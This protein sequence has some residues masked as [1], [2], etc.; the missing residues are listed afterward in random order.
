REESSYGIISFNG[1]QTLGGNAD[2]LFQGQDGL[3]YNALFL[4]F[5]N[6]SLT[7]GPG[8][9]IHGKAASIG[10]S[11]ILRPGVHLTVINQG[12]IVA[13]IPGQTFTL[14]AENLQNSGVLSCTNGGR[15][16]LQRRETSGTI[17]NGGA[18]SIDENSSLTTNADLHQISGSI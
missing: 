1:T 2:V 13:E 4:P 7:I 12:T 9:T 18:I 3:G 17:R 8:I 10:F 11:D 15:L 5:D 16:V 14:G 6:S